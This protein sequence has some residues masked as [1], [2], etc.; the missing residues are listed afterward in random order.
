[1]TAASG[2][3]DI[4]FKPVINDFR[5]MQRVEIQLVDWR[6]SEGQSSSLAATAAASR[7]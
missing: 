6:V 1:L 4:A 2:P 7:G 3:L 5:G